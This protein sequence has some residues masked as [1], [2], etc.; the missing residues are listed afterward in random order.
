M[1][2]CVCLGVPYG[3]T[4]GGQGL[5]RSLK[6]FVRSVRN[7]CRSVLCRDSKGFYTGCFLVWRPCAPFLAAHPVS[8]SLH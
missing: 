8:T 6:D 1:C 2:V 4:R 5:V 7:S 3:Y